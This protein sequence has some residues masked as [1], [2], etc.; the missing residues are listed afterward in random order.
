VL[1]HEH[2]CAPEE[3]GQAGRRDQQLSSYRIHAGSVTDV[4]LG[5]TA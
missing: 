3:V 1:E 5:E 2:D 4:K